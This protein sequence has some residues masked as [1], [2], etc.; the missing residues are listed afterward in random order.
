[1]RCE[2]SAHIGDFF[3]FSIALNKLGKLAADT[4]V[5]AANLLGHTAGSKRLQALH[6]HL[7]KFMETEAR[8]RNMDGMAKWPK[9]HLE[10]HWQQARD[11]AKEKE[12]CTRALRPRT[13]GEK[14]KRKN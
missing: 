7:H 11:A 1:M 3:K 6:P 9:E 13:C 8:Q 4:G 10:F 2:I 14:R 12:L 5:D